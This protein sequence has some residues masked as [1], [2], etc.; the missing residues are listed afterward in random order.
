M[1]FIKIIVDYPTFLDNDC[2]RCRVLII[3]PGYDLFL[4]MPAIGE[5]PEN[6][7][8]YCYP[9]ALEIAW[10][11]FSQPKNLD[12][13]SKFTNFCHLQSIKTPKQ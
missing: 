3:H 7:K 5:L 10:N 11:L 8:L 13:T 6:T 12:T 9:G 4:P 1:I 2:G